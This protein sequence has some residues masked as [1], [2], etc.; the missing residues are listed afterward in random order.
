MDTAPVWFLRPVHAIQKRNLPDHFFLQLWPRVLPPLEDPSSISLL[1][2]LSSSWVK[3]PWTA[4]QSHHPSPFSWSLQS[5][6]CHR[7]LL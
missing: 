1:P 3:G 4:A 6:L 7:T 5:K 2:T